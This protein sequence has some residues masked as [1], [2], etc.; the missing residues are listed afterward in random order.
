MLVKENIFM[1]WLR[2]KLRKWLGIDAEESQ[3]ALMRAILSN[4]SDDM[5]EFDEWR[6]ELTKS[7]RGKPSQPPRKTVVYSDYETSQQIA[8]KDFEEK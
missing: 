5:K 3:Q 8:L 4:L 7:M 1:Q 6:K 2:R